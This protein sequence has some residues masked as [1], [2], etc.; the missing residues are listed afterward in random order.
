MKEHHR[1]YTGSKLAYSPSKSK[2]EKKD[3]YKKWQPE[4]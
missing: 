3:S 4:S 2:K 1:N